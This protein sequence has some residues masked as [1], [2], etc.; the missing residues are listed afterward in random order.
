MKMVTKGEIV[1]P[2]EIIHDAL[3]EAKDVGPIYWSCA[4][5]G[6]LGSIVESL[7]GKEE[8]CSISFKRL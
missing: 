7:K 3:N 1:K 6:S 5:S 4:L 8:L 2:Q